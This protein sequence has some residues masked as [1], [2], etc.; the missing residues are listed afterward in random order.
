MVGGGIGSFI[1][2]VHRRAAELD[3]NI[4]LV[5]GAFSRDPAASRQ[6][7]EA[8]GI[9]V[10]RAYPDY[11]TM[12]REEAK[13]TDGIDLVT[14]VTPND[15]HFAIACAALG[16]GVHVMSD[17]PATATLAQALELSKV[18][19]RS[20]RHYALS[21]SYTGYA[22]L[23]E[24]RSM[25]AAGA[26]GTLRKIVVEY[27][28]GWLADPVETRNNRQA[29]WRTDPAR[30]GI[31]GCIGDIGVHAFNLAEFVSGERVAQIN[32]E[33]QRIVP[34]RILDDDA[35]ILA[36][37][38]NGATGIIACSQIATGERNNLRI[39]LWGDKGG[40]D[41]SHERPDLLT[42]NWGS[43]K[44]EQRHAGWAGLTADAHAATRLPGGHPEGFIEALANIYSD[45]RMAILHEAPATPLQ[46]IEEGVRSMSFL[47]QAVTGAAD[48][49]G[50]RRL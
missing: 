50:W 34:G 47:E 5:A 24:A 45:L 46:G 23:R 48:N 26:L 30:A 14:I 49:D 27:Y 43:G 40:L 41:W 36:R 38:A 4:R 21:Y 33:L 13:R 35:T 1:G 28:Q 29:A 19:K 20:G 17:K 12:L 15:T 18:V 7:G 11:E 8:Y 37:F 9:D 3:G 39:R 6:A 10:D 44:S 31:G 16:A 32:P 22:M 2:P 25:V 42:I